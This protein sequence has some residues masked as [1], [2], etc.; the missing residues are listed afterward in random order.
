MPAFGP[1]D[2]KSKGLT[3]M[4]CAVI[5]LCLMLCWMVF[6]ILYLTYSRLMMI[7]H[8]NP[9]AVM[10]TGHGPGLRANAGKHTYADHHP[11][12]DPHVPHYRFD[13]ANLIVSLGSDFLGTWLSPVEFTQMF[14]SRRDL[15]AHE[16]GDKHDQP[17]DMARLV[18]FEGYLSLTGANAD[19]RF[20]VRYT[21]LPY[22][23][24]ALAN[25]VATNSPRGNSAIRGALSAFS[26]EAV[27][28]TTGLPAKV[29]E[30]LGAELLERGVDLAVVLR[31]Q[32]ARLV[33]PGDD[34]ADREA[35]ED[36]VERAPERRLRRRVG[37]HRAKVKAHSDAAQHVHGE[38]E[39][40]LVDVHAALAVLAR[41]PQLPLERELL[42]GLHHAT[43]GLAENVVLAVTHSYSPVRPVWISRVI[44]LTM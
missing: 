14:S 28:T 34:R 37:G 36:H 23:A 43:H 32:P 29:I 42:R 12:G 31:R 38:L 25:V 44:V 30:R 24:L 8:L 41:Q 6:A 15:S 11:S 19:N 3:V 10:E 9:K 4:K 13:K 17:A 22:V 35:V 18:A 26:P 16:Y 27:A 40:L 21:D 2:R 5:G 7:T 20:R 39:H 1:N 33:Q